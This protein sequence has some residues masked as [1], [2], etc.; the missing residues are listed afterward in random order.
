MREAQPSFSKPLHAIRGIAALVVVLAHVWIPVLRF[1]P[2]WK[3]VAAYFNSGSAVGLFFVL[4][5]LVLTLSL[6]RMPDNLSSYAAYA[7]RRLFRLL[8]LLGTSVFVGSACIIFLDPLTTIPFQDIGPLEVPH[9][10]AAFI[11][12][13]IRPN[14]PSWSIYVEIVISLVLPLMWVA[15]NSG[16][17]ISLI[18]AVVIVSSLDARLQ[19]RWNFYLINFLAGM[20]ILSWGQSLRFSSSVAFWSAFS[21][22]VAVFYFDRAIVVW[23]SG[24]ERT[25]TDNQWINLLDVVLVTP[26]LAAVFH[27]SERFLWLGNKVGTFL[28]EVSYSIY[29][30]HWFV[31]S[32]VSNCVIGFWPGAGLHAGAFWL[33]SAA[34]VLAIVIPLSYV[35]YRWIELPGL[36]LGKV[37]ANRISASVLIPKHPCSNSRDEIKSRVGLSS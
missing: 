14:P 12:Y 35:S 23:I 7:I 13:S 2:T 36:R 3:G 9:F 6:K 16:Y 18:V 17:K 22:L 28:G 19:H 29:L 32:I 37:L 15:Y 21:S 31:V 11:G 25:L 34:F 5:G 26:I 10:L 27:N 30:N 1:D 8:P 24:Y 4:S 20:S 33:I